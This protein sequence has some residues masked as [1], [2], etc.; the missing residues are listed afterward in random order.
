VLPEEEPR[1]LAA[2][3]EAPEDDAAERRAGD[4]RTGER[5]EQPGTGRSAFALG[6]DTPDAVEVAPIATGE[7]PAE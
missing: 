5:R 6:E 4:R 7:T 1:E 3:F 2:A